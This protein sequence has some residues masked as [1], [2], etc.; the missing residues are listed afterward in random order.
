[1]GV[2]SFWFQ[3]PQF[4]C[5]GKAPTQDPSQS[6]IS[7]ILALQLILLRQIQPDPSMRRVMV[8]HRGGGGGDVW[9]L[10]AKTPPPHYPATNCW[11]EAL[12][13]GGGGDG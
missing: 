2:K 12:L 4:C 7:D 6:L 5:S 11:P 9:V 10:E 13:G 1:M 8:A 3:R